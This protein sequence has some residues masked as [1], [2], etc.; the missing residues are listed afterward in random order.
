MTAASGPPAK[1]A[2]PRASPATPRAVVL[3]P[4]LAVNCLGRAHVLARLLQPAFD[5]AIVGPATGP[6]WGPLREDHSLPTVAVPMPASAQEARRGDG[7]RVWARVE[8]EARALRPDLVYVSKPFASSL[9]VA[10]RLRRDGAAV[11]LDIDDTEVGILLDS[12][13]SMPARDRLRFL[14]R[15]QRHHHREPWNV[16]AGAMR[17]RGVRHRTVSNQQLQRRYGGTLVPHVR[18]ADLLDPA[19]HTPAQA[20]SLLRLP[21]AAGLVL[22]LGTPRATKGLETL[23]EAVAQ[24]PDAT[25]AIVGMDQTRY[26]RSL[27]GSANARL[28]ARA[29]LRPPV[30]FAQV[31]D[32]MAAAD[33]VAIPQE[34]NATSRGQMPAKVFDA[35]AMA[36]PIVAT[37]VSDLPDVLEGCGDLVP[38]GDT[39]AM[40]DAVRRL[41]ADRDRSA[42]LGRAARAR[43]LE[44]YSLQAV[45]PL[46]HRLAQDA[47]AARRRRA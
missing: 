38:P 46:V 5:V 10:R 20:R 31:P 3:C 37:A 1:S 30:P 9:G 27:A 42:A 8:E 11:L 17:A 40:A 36:R 25:L 12:L 21:P 44:R 28:G 13:R 29:I 47:L 45:R 15:H 16:L 14:G 39:A 43:F 6:L 32:W 18:D 26:A 35:M 34:D 24:V 2:S 33:V 41:L 7:R 22:F 23:V 4:D 19:G